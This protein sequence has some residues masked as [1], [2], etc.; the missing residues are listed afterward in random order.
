MNLKVQGHVQGKKKKKGTRKEKTGR[1]KEKEKLKEKGY[2]ILTRGNINTF[3]E[4]LLSKEKMFTYSWGGRGWAKG[5]RSV[6]DPN[7]DPWHTL[8]HA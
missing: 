5:G 8:A 3:Q 2:D 7:L 6:L 1:K 4:K